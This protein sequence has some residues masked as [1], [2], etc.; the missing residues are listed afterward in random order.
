MPVLHA[1]SAAE[2]DS[3]VKSKAGFNQRNAVLVDFT[4]TWQGQAV[5]AQKTCTPSSHATP[6]HMPRSW[7]TNIRY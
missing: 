2:F 1:R 6:K 7:N 3:I 5:R 4:A